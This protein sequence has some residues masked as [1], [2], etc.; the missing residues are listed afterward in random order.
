MLPFIILSMGV[1]S[2]HTPNMGIIGEFQELP[3][4]D[5][6]SNFLPLPIQGTLQ[7]VNISEE[8]ADADSPFMYPYSCNL[9]S[10][11]RV[12][13]GTCCPGISIYFLVLIPLKYGPFNISYFKFSSFLIY[14]PCFI[15]PPKQFWSL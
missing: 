5:M 8:K 3:L 9:T 10:Q 11:R 15:F 1:L 6:P 2:K 12:L 7:L 4:P 13:E 14:L